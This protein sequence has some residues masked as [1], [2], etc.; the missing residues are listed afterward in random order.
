MIGD[1]GK[2]KVSKSLSTLTPL[3][4]ALL[5]DTEETSLSLEDQ[6]KNPNCLNKFYKVSH[7]CEHRLTSV[8]DN[9]PTA[10][11]VNIGIN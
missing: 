10:L 9:P 7:A 5:Q 1:R 8:G 6:Q 2:R 4:V 3:M 11:A